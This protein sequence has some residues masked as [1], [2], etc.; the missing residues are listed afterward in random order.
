MRRILGLIAALAAV[1]CEAQTSEDDDAS[2][3]TQEV[4][5]ATTR[6]CSWNVRRLGHD[7]DDRPKDIEVTATIID[8]HCDVIAVQEVMQ[9]DGG[10]T[11]GYVALLEQLGAD[12]GG[13]ITE[14]PRPA[15][16]SANS[17]HYA[18]YFRKSHATLCRGWK[19]AR[20]I[21][22]EEDAFLRE[23]AWTCLKLPGRKR[24]LLLVSYHAV[25]GSP[26]ERRREVGWLD[27]DLDH[28]G[29]ADDVLRGIRA[30]R[31]SEADV[32]I[33]GDFNLGS[34][35]LA[36]ALP[37]FVD[38]ADGKGSTLNLRD[39]ITD[40]LFDHVIVPADDAAGL[41]ATRAEVLDVRK[42]MKGDTFFRSVSDHLPVRFQLAPSE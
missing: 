4:S 41:G 25:Y 33:V 6:I 19:A 29:K 24:D 11:P 13:V 39:E 36:E 7:F 9:K 2:I 23:P 16:P 32:M 21:A 12:W 15:S 22:D 8:T 18:F 27:D 31:S 40:N 42:Y 38:L 5:T 34:S 37:R 10:A 28:D 1:A 14:Q 17:E 20:T 3:V 35:E 26:I 30:S